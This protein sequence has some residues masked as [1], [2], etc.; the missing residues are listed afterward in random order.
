M[1]AREV[2]K[3]GVRIRVQGQPLKVLLMFLERPGEVVTREELRQRLW[4]D[5]TFVDFEHGLNSALTRLRQALADSADSPRYIETLPKQGY[6]FIAPVM[7]DRGAIRGVPP[8]AQVTIRSKSLPPVA[9]RILRDAIL[10]GLAIAVFSVFAAWR[11]S[12]RPEPPRIL[13]QL[14]DDLGLSTDPAISP[15]GKFLAY[16]SDRNGGH[17]NIWLKQISTPARGIQLTHFDAD[18]HQ[19]TFSPDGSRVA[20]RREGDG[21]GIY[22]VPAIGGDPIRIASFGRDPRFS[23]DGKWL[24]F[25]VNADTDRTSGFSNGVMYVMPASG[26]PP[27]RVGPE[28][29]G[30]PVWA[31]DSRHLLVS[32]TV[33]ESVADWFVIPLNGSPVV[34]T[35]VFSVLRKQEFA[36]EMGMTLP[37]PA[38]WSGDHVLFSAKRGDAVNIWSIRLPSQDPHAG[39]PAEQLTFGTG[40]DVNPSLADGHLVFASLTEHTAIWSLPIEPNRMKVT[41]K[42]QRI[43]ESTASEVTP[44]TTEDGRYVAFSSDRSRGYDVYI[45]DIQTGDEVALAATADPEWHP[46]FFRD[47]SRVAYTNRGANQGIYTVPVRGGPAER[48][49]DGSGFIWSC[50]RDNQRLLFKKDHSSAEVRVLNLSSKTESVFLRREGM[51]LFQAKYSPDD[52]WLAVEAVRTQGDSRIYVVP[53]K[54][55]SPGA[56]DSWIPIVDEDAWADKPRWSPDGN[57]LYFISQRDGFRCVWAQPLDRETKQPSGAALAV[58][59]FHTSGLS[60]ANVPVNFIEIDVARSNLLLTLGE[61]TGNIWR[62]R[63]P[64]HPSN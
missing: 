21:G 59:H 48:V 34:R 6:R 46:V 44:D 33:P 23:P 29:S 25:W 60:L 43:T 45:K 49:G 18:T 37:R 54:D 7:Q 13:E 55:G 41:G 40:S 50:S 51:N 39:S 28:I 20:F 53:L 52:R 22:I 42:F 19:P 58:Q 26:G 62:S 56:I 47:G 32:R 61:F 57:S 16:A 4:P 2:R 5:K 64:G 14:T 27:E 10:L 15:D 63:I 36:L 35:G 12:T 31:S 24:A 17:L 3:Q 1:R 8:P 9:R 38:A 30:A 11:L